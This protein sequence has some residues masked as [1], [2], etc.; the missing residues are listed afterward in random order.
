MHQ[1]TLPMVHLKPQAR[2]IL[3]VLEDGLP[4]SA[5][6]FKRGTWG[7]YCDAVSQRIGEIRRAGFDVANVKKD[8]GVAVY[9]LRRSVQ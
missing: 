5:L 4:H 9:Q 7:F 3:A 8:G 6:E 2:D 1:T